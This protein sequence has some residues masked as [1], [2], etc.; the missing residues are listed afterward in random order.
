[1]FKLFNK[2]QNQFVQELK[3]NFTNSCGVS[4]CGYHFE[5]VVFKTKAL[6][7]SNAKRRKSYADLI[8]VEV[9]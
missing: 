5:D 8:V 4:T 1:M 2:R 6:A 7:L 3:S 9:K